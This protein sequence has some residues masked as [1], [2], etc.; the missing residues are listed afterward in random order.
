MQLNQ[1]TAQVCGL[2]STITW[3]HHNTRYSY[4]PTEDRQYKQL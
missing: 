3:L 4:N 1:L 2:S